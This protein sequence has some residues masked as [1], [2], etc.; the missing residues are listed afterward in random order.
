MKLYSSTTLLWGN[1]FVDIC[2]RAA[3]RGLSGLE[4]WSEQARFQGWRLPEMR[5]GLEEQSLEATVHS[6]SWDLNICSLNP[7]IQRASLDEIERSILFAKE[8]KASSVTIHPGRLTLAEPGLKNWHEDE[9]RKSLAMIDHWAQAYEIHVS[10]EMMEHRAKEVLI[11]PAT[12]NEAIQMCSSWMCTTYD[13]A[14]TPLHEDPLSY[15]YRLKRVEK[16]HLSDSSENVYHLPLGEGKI[17]FEPFLHAISTELIPVV[18]EGFDERGRK[19]MLDK[20]LGYLD[21]LC[22]REKGGVGA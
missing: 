8:I 15:Y 2:E 18:L 7:A 9:L 12:M 16:I 10:L 6:A 21:H 4:I 20:H 19:G 14:H 17:K 5:V 22:V 13:V 1:E 3:E 11:D